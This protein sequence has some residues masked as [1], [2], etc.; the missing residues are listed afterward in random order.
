MQKSQL[1]WYMKAIQTQLDNWSQ[2]KPCHKLSYCINTLLHRFSRGRRKRY[3]WYSLCFLD[4]GLS[5]GYI[6]TELMTCCLSRKQKNLVVFWK[7]FNSYVYVLGDYD[8]INNSGRY[9][10]CAFCNLENIVTKLSKGNFRSWDIGYFSIFSKIWEC[11]YSISFWIFIV[12]LSTETCT[13][14][15]NICLKRDWI[16]TFSAE[17]TNHEFRLNITRALVAPPLEP[18]E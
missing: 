14:K 6:Q 2:N 7:I 9:F 13:W 3:W 5:T 18:L 15:L 10:T 11:T 12:S 16:S 4:A 8:T 17:T 1:S